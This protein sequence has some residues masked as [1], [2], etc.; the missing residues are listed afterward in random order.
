MSVDLNIK[1]DIEVLRLQPGDVLVVS[2][3]GHVPGDIY[4]RVAEQM[5]ERFPDHEVIVTRDITLSVQRQETA[6]V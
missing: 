1:G 2:L 6:C 5:R 4:A 3:E